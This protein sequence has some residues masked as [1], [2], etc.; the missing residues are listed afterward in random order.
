MKWPFFRRRTSSAP[1]DERGSRLGAAE[2]SRLPPIESI[3]SPLEEPHATT[4]FVEG[5]ATRR[6]LPVSL[7]RLEHLISETAPSGVISALSLVPARRPRRLGRR[8]EASRS[9]RRDAPSIE[10]LSTVL[11]EPPMEGPPQSGRTAEAVPAARRMPQREWLPAPAISPAIRSIGESAHESMPP[12][13]GPETID[14]PTL[15]H[16]SHA[17]A[18]PVDAGPVEESE[19][20]M[21][22]AAEPELQPPADRPESVEPGR[23]SEVTAPQSAVGAAE[24]ATSVRDV[25]AESAARAVPSRL[26]SALPAGP[27]LGAVE[28]AARNEIDEV[29]PPPRFRLTAIARRL[30]EPLAPSAVSPLRPARGAVGAEPLPVPVPVPTIPGPP[31]AAHPFLAP[32]AT[33]PEAAPHVPPPSAPPASASAAAPALLPRTPTAAPPRAAIAEPVVPPWVPADAAAAA[34]VEPSLPDLETLADDLYEHL[35][36]RLTQELVLDRERTLF[37]PEFR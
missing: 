1:G 17:D 31:P 9:P 5:L 33:P 7:G 25:L 34:V 19:P 16:R 12:A 30:A 10:A 21:A 20:D 4:E 8:P 15:I 13:F 18:A 23:V 6:P 32:A 11:E 3:L 14:A 22:T 26:Q 24:S 36:A 35:R 2:W 37:T 27:T 28:T 29:I